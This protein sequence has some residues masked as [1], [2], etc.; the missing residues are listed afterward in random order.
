MAETIHCPG[1]AAVLEIRDEHVAQQML[2]AN[3][4]IAF[5]GEDESPNTGE[6]A[7]EQPEKKTLNKRI[8]GFDLL[9]RIGMGGMGAV[10]KARQ[11]SLDKIVAVKLLKPDMAKN[12]H[13]V[14]RFFREARSA[15]RLNHPNIVKA[16]EV[17]ESEG[18]HFFAMEYAEGRTL[19]KIIQDEGSIL[20]EE[21][22]EIALQ[23]CAALA[24]AWKYRIIHRDIKPDNIMILPDGSIKVM[25]MGLAK[26]TQD[27]DATLTQAGRVIGTP[28][29]ASPEQLRGKVHDLDIR[30]DIYS[31]GC[32]LFHAITGRLPFD[33]STTGVIV[34]NN[35]NNDLPPVSEFNPELTEEFDDLIYRM[36]R[37]D[38]EQRY[39]DPDDVVNAINEILEGGDGEAAGEK[40][41]DAKPLPIISKPRRRAVRSRAR[42]RKQSRQQFIAPL[43]SIVGL[44]SAAYLW[45]LISDSDQSRE[46]RSPVTTKAPSRSKPI[47]TTK[48]PI[49]SPSSSRTPRGSRD[50]E[51][52]FRPRILELIGGS[53]PSRNSPADDEGPVELIPGEN[54]ADNQPKIGEIAEGFTAPITRDIYEDL[55]KDF[56]E[57]LKGNL[58]NE[59]IIGLQSAK[60]QA[61]YAF[62]N[63]PSS[64]EE[65]EARLKNV[66]EL[67]DAGVLHEVA[68]GR[69]QAGWVR[70]L[71]RHSDSSSSLKKLIDERRWLEKKKNLFRGNAERHLVN[72]ALRSFSKDVDD[73]VNI[74]KL[75]AQQL[76]KEGKTGEAFALFEELN[77]KY[78]ELLPE[79]FHKE[80]E[81]LKQLAG[82]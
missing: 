42:R 60:V 40:S 56:D 1:C 50:P 58:T 33:G 14:E 24:H 9:E 78:G 63:L 57:Y 71:W 19:H 48:A 55:K 22:L 77:T 4:G 18:Y 20:E 36:T 65:V 26:S 23:I 70:N 13:F 54:P 7:A 5:G 25:D 75:E 31:L 53:L 69:L 17:G 43:V 76:L 32:T 68:A 15:A 8:G 21:A 10:F 82:R 46:P 12:Q 74:F 47:R 51:P 3:C 80:Y 67:A 64:R 11:I 37:K 34:S 66:Y 27:N 16:I 73:H 45:T 81:R 28:S 61:A 79:N 59:D 49:E 38:R 72:I 41:A 52:S 62:H 30:T 44:V 2:C 39:S 29:Y 35:L 6:Q